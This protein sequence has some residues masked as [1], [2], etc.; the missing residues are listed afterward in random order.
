[1]ADEEELD[2]DI[3]EVVENSAR[4]LYGLIHARYIVTSRGLSKMVSRGFK[5][6]TTPPPSPQWMLLCPPSPSHHPP[7]RDSRD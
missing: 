5:F 7:Q 3:R 2:D 6:T 4:F 1:M